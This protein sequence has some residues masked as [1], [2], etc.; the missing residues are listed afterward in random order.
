VKKISAAN[1]NLDDAGREPTMPAYIA[2]LRGINVS[3]HNTIK[4]EHLRAL[5]S[6]L[7]FRNVETYVQSGN[8]VFQTRIE[9][10]SNLSRRIS[11]TILLASRFDVPVIV[12]S[13]IE[14]QSV[15]ANN[16]FL[17]EKGIDSSKLYVTFL[18]ETVQE[19]VLKK[20]EPLSKDP[21]RFYG[22]PREI[23][24]YCPGG[25]GRT[26]LSNNAIEKALSV[27]ATTRNWKT[28]NTLLEMVSKL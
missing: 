15:I 11:E 8:I 13:S 22:A 28:T 21:D 9:N 2:M 18:S 7:G 19:S 10:P 26:K 27:R 23:Y 4:M 6:D 14:M 25:Y 20:L 16:P 5:F 12:R 17:K 3:G 24:L 1:S